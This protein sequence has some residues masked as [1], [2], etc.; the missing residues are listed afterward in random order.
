MGFMG[1]SLIYS[2]IY[3]LYIEEGWIKNSLT[4]ISGLICS[5]RTL[6]FSIKR[7]ESV[8]PLLESGKAVESVSVDRM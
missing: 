5:S 4:S 3:E 6:P 1:S 8:S 2:L 7:G